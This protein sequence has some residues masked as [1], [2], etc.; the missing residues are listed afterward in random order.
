MRAA[1]KHMSGHRAT[2]HFV[3]VI[4]RPAKVRNGG[5]Q[6]EG[7]IRHTTGHNNVCAFHERLR[8]LKGADVGIGTD[9]TG[10]IDIRTEFF[11]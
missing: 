2:A 9:N 5:T 3:P 11:E 6:R 7:W 8:N 4:H 10:W 1:L